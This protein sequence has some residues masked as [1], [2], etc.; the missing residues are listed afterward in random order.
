MKNICASEPTLI[1]SVVSAGVALAMGFGLTITTQQM[2]LIMAFA[3]AVLGVINRSQVT[4]PAS[5]AAMKPKDLD[6]AQKTPE[7]VKDVVTKLP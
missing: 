6:A 3:S 7:P 4:S 2:G 5:L 1:L